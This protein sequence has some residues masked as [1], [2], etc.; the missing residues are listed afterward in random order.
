MSNNTGRG[1]NRI[2]IHPVRCSV[3]DVSIEVEGRAGYPNYMDM[4]QLL[5]NL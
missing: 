3:A 5:E 2:N 1:K 4:K